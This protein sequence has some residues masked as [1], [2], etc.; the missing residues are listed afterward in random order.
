MLLELLHTK[1]TRIL[2]DD[3]VRIVSRER[4]NVR[5]ETLEEVAAEYEAI[6]AALD[7]LDRARYA[8]L[9]DLRMAPPRNDEAYEDIARRHNARLYAGFR[10]VAV[11]VQTAA[12]RLQLRRFLDVSRPDAAVF[13]DEREAR[14]FL[15]GA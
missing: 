11:L 3:T 1:H 7:G 10:R 8:S 6:G 15:A 13:V 2:A 14:A 9:V 5:F 12:G 4:T